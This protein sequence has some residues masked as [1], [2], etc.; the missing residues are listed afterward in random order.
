MI[1]H[2]KFLNKAPDGCLQ[3]FTD[4]T[5]TV[6]SFNYLFTTTPVV[7][8]LAYQDYQICIRSNTVNIFLWYK[9]FNI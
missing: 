3:W 8:H 5:G 4:P 6:M 9:H 7:Q 1:F 2:N